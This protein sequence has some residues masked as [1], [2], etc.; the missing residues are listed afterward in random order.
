MLASRVNRKEPPHSEA[1]SR[2]LSCHGR[3]AR[4]MLNQSSLWR[5]GSSWP[6]GSGERGKGSGLELQQSDFARQA[7]GIASQGA[8]STE[9]PV[10]GQ[11]DSQGLR[12]TAAP[13]ARAALGRPMAADS[14]L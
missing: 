4:K 1:S 11:D 5:D 8:T 7:A 14:A 9:H 3:L 2:K 10:A 6:A 12:P 13:T